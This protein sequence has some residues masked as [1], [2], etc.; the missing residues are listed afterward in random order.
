[1]YL[2]SGTVLDQNRQ[3]IENQTMTLYEF[4][5]TTDSNPKQNPNPPGGKTGVSRLGVF[6]DVVAFYNVG[7]PAPQPGQFWN[8]K[9][10]LT[11]TTKTQS[12][13]NIRINCTYKEYDHATV[14][15]VTSTPNSACP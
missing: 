9:Q 15:D 14:T 13:N 7:P 3:A 6:G 11:V 1:M 8:I 2:A 12:Y 4:L 5:Q 10:F